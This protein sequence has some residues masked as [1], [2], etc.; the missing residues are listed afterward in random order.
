MRMYE[1]RIL[2]SKDYS[3]WKESGHKWKESGYKKLDDYLQS[4]F[5]ESGW[6]KSLASSPRVA[7]NRAWGCAFGNRQIKQDEEMTILVRHPKGG[8]QNVYS[9]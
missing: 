7:V 8:E 1:V 2:I 3:G 6:I 5:Q 9:I 4:G